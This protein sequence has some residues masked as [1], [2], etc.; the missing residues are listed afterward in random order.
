MNTKNSI[1][2]FLA[3]AALS[4]TACN[5]T[6]DSTVQWKKDNQAAYDSITVN[7]EWKL[8]DTG[9][10]PAGVYY[11]IIATGSGEENPLQTATV[12]VNYIGYFLN[13]NTQV[14]ERG[15]SSTLLIND[16]PR[17]F[18]IALQKMVVGDKWKICIPYYLGYGTV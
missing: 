12:K 13:D 7:P 15:I 6:D 18:G 16:K 17:G 8:L 1:F 10:G 9:D 11:Q 14:F 4:F 3:L 5:E 2:L